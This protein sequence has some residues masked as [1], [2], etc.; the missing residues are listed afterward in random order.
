MQQAEGWIT[1]MSL[2][3]SV[4]YDVA[5]QLVWLLQVCRFAPADLAA[6]AKQ[7]RPVLQRHANHMSL[8]LAHSTSM[9]LCTAEVINCVTD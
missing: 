1:Y 7:P 9:Q 8:D 2:L 5:W 4:T 3:P 6:P